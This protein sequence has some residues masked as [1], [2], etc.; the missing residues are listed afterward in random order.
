MKDAHMRLVSLANRV[1]H[2]AQMVRVGYSVVRPLYQACDFVVI[3]DQ[4]DHKYVFLPEN[5]PSELRPDPKGRKKGRPYIKGGKKI[6][7]VLIDMFE[8]PIKGPDGDFADIWVGTK[9]DAQKQLDAIHSG[10]GG[11]THFVKVVDAPKQ[12]QQPVQGR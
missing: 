2:L 7:D 9:T 6:Y 8:S 12:K 3:H 5:K 11:G 4:D 10:L 1:F